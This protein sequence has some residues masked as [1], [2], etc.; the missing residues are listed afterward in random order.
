ML[1]CPTSSSNET[2]ARPT[3][4]TKHRSNR[5]S[6]GVEARWDSSG[7]RGN[8][9]R[10]QGLRAPGI[11]VIAA[12]YHAGAVGPTLTQEAAS[13]SDRIILALGN[14]DVVGA[15]RRT[16]GAHRVRRSQR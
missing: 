11:S 14:V 15:D 7:L 12:P 5:H 9:G 13:A 4:T 1:L 8:I 2:P 10:Y 16:K 3:A 6:N